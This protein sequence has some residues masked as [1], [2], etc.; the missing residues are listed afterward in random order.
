MSANM[1]VSRIDLKH[2]M[3]TYTTYQPNTN[4]NNNLYNSFDQNYNKPNYESNYG[5]Q[6]P[7]SNKPNYE[8]GYGQHYTP[9]NPYGMDGIMVPGLPSSSSQFPNQGMPSPMLPPQFPMTQRPTQR[10]TYS[11]S[12]P[13]QQPPPTTTMVQVPVQTKPAFVVPNDTDINSICGTRHSETEITPFIFGGEDTKRG[14]WPWM[15]SSLQAQQR[16][17]KK[18]SKFFRLFRYF[19]GCNLFE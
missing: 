3:N 6:Y 15:V 16:N 19:P 11:P 17:L 9:S 12:P 2:V 14:D 4:I 10:P 18:K 1:V 7:S 8:S 13:P 5:N